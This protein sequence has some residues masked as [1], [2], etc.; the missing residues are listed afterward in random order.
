MTRWLSPRPSVICAALLAFALVCAG[1]RRA[2]QRDAGATRLAPAPTWGDLDGDGHPDEVVIQRHGATDTVGLL[3]STARTDVSLD[4]GP[5]FVAVSALDIDG[6]GDVDLITTSA[7]GAEFW[8]NDGHGVFTR[9]R[10]PASRTL[11]APPMADSGG[12]ASLLAVC[13]TPSAITV[14]FVVDSVSDPTRMSEPASEVKVSTP[15]Q[16]ACRPR[17]P[18]APSARA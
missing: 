6:D 2:A 12:D 14:R 1:N 18:P 8:L 9:S 13:T 16:S 11:S 3:L 4:V 10:R 17:A 7:S 5:G 15:S